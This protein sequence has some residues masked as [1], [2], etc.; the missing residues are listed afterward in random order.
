MCLSMVPKSEV[1]VRGQKRCV[2]E[3]E[4]ESINVIRKWYETYERF[5]IDNAAAE[6]RQNGN[7][8][9]W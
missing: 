6:T 1:E 8:A 5:I 7:S 3:K 9:L 4:V 2:A